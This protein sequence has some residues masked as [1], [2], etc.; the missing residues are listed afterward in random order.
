MIID[1]NLHKYTLQ[2]LYSILRLNR[3]IDIITHKKVALDDIHK[4]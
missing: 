3:I 2:F 1:K 4:S